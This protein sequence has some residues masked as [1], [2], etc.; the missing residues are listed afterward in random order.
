MQSGLDDM[1]KQKMLQAKARSNEVRR[2]KF[3][4]DEIVH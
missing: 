4:W 2:G 1:T 3:G